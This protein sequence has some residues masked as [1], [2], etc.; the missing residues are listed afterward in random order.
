M[1]GVERIKCESRGTDCLCTGRYSDC[2]YWNRI[3]S[4]IYREYEHKQGGFPVPVFMSVG[5]SSG[6]WS[7]KLG[8]CLWF[9]RLRQRHV[10]FVNR[11]IST[12]L[13]LS[14]SL[15]FV[16]GRVTLPALPWASL[17][18]SLS[19][20]L[21]VFLWNKPYIY[22]LSVA[23]TQQLCPHVMRTFSSSPR[24]WLIL[25]LSLL[26]H[27]TLAELLPIII[28]RKRPLPGQALWSF[29]SCFLPIVFSPGQQF[30]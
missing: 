14:L 15:S 24:L 2:K 22:T 26:F 3:P 23:T 27:Q 17:C 28:G 10:V 20:S 13:W 4:S 16:V 18:F 7:G 29:T 8:R 30:W 1:R 25:S 21:S 5:I 19:H 12:Q 9:I 11:I 6:H